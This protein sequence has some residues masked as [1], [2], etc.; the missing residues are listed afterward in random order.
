MKLHNNLRLLLYRQTHGVDVMISGCRGMA[1]RGRLRRS[2]KEAS[3]GSSSEIKG[4]GLKDRRPS[5]RKWKR[6]QDKKG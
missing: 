1:P 5:R 3:L 4:E 6:S 2:H